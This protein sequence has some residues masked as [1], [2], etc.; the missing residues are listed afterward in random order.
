MIMTTLGSAYWPRTPEGRILAPLLSLFAIG[1][2]GYITA[3]LAS[4]FVDRDAAA[5]DSAT[6][7]ESELRAIRREL[8][9]LREELRARAD[10]RT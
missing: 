9:L 3:S 6:A 2:F 1:V 7:S 4:F 10:G 5:A 8:R